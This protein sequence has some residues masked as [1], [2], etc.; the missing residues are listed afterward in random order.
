MALAT[1][2]KSAI[3]R[4]LAL[5]CAWYL[6]DDWRARRRLARGTLETRSGTRHARLGIEASLSYI[7]KIHGDYLAYAGRPR[8]T[9]TVAEIGPGDNFGV[10]A[11]LL[12]HG[13]EAV[14]AIDRYRPVR[15]DTGQAAIY[16]ALSDRHRL[17][18]CFDGPP[19]ERTIRCLTY[20]PGQPAESFFANAGIRFDAVLSRAV[21]EHLYDPLRAL[22]H[23][24]A[25]LNPGGI[26]VHRIDLRDHGMFAGLHPLTFLT[27]PE[28]LY[29][30]MTA[31]AGRP[32]RV[33]A[34]A[35]R[36][37]IGSSG[38]RGS[39]R[40]TRLAGLPGEIAPARWPDIDPALRARALATV[41]TIRPRLAPALAKLADQDLAISGCVL[42]AEKPAA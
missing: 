4:S 16:A 6:L 19:S 42:I 21:L 25:A 35:W 26:M 13:A 14:H 7:E 12:G 38:L 8:F 27:L 34:P 24:A 29:R 28:G 31:G 11:L 39:L 1:I 41:G 9:G 3:R 36:D 18:D 17:A 2:L 15:D 40:V 37:W 30:R 23:M 22:D 33:L 32:N 5:T 20:H 10:A